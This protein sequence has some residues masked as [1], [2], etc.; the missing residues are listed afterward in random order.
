MGRHRPLPQHPQHQRT[1]RPQP[2]QRLIAGSLL[3]QLSVVM[4]LPKAIKTSN[5]FAAGAKN[6]KP[7]KKVQ[8]LSRVSLAWE[9][10]VIWAL[11]LLLVLSL[12]LKGNSTR[13]VQSSAHKISQLPDR[14]VLSHLEQSAS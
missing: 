8:L 13:A 5:R 4:Y 7:A 12:A 14:M 2:H 1:P 6:I 11:Q 3:V 10:A 9:T